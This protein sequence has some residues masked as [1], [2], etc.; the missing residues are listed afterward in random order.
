MAIIKGTPGNDNLLGT[1]G[2]DTIYGYAGDDI[3]NGNGGTD[4]LIGGLGNDTYYVNNTTTTV[5]ENANEGT[6]TVISSVS[7]TLPTN[8]ENLTLAMG[9][10]AINGTGNSENNI[11]YGN[12]SANI[13]DG[14]A[15]ADTMYGG[16]G[17]DT[18]IVDNVG[19]QVIENANQGIDTVNASVT[20]TW[21]WQRVSQCY[22]RQ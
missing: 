4:T 21:N 20:Y 11:I 19:D 8:V 5:K 22:N 10:G 17:N 18:Y 14:K 6:D 1:T 7:Y 2:N 15:G 3:L 13:L 12:E 9:A 16:D